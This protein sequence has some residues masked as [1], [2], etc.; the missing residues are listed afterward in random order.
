MDVQYSLINIQYLYQKYPE[1]TRNSNHKKFI[2]VYR[3][4]SHEPVKKK[5][6]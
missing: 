4:D 2:V 5:F 6:F 3:L 1:I